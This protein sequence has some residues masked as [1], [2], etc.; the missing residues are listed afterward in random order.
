[1]R[2]SACGVLLVAVVACGIDR[3]RAEPPVKGVA[4]F[5][6]VIAKAKA[7]VFPAVAFVKPIVED[8]KAGRKMS[9]EIAGSGVVISAHGELVTNWHVVRKAVDIRVQLSDGTCVK[10]TLVGGDKETDIALVRL[11]KRP[12]KA[13]YAHAAFADSSRLE[14]GDFVMAM[15]A[16]WGLSRSVSLGILSCTRR[17]LPNQ[18]EYS[19]WL[20]TDASLNPGNSGGPLV[21]CEGKVAGVNTLAAM[22]GGDIGFAV[23]ANTVKYIVDQLRLHGEVKRSWTGVRL[24]P[25]N[26]FER[27]TFFDATEGVIVAGT[28]PQSPGR[29]AGLQAGDRITAVGGAPVTAR[30][31]EDLPAIRARL[32]S[33]EE[34]KAAALSVVREGKTLALSLTPRPKGAVEGEELDCPRWNMT[35]KTINQFDNP[36]L[37]FHRKKGVFILAVKYPG[38]AATSGLSAQDII[39]KIGETAVTALADVKAAYDKA[40]SAKRDERKVVVEVI[41]DGLTNHVVLDYAREYEDDE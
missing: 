32:G 37:Y 20:Q 11:A 4:D 22:S 2:I 3:G 12:D 25:L 33:L 6:A 38:N 10:G 35:V 15:G 34:G 9:H 8:F 18:S 13:P 21:T 29:R 28:D 14:E 40:L 39:V 23:P 16:P 26:D 19:L 24:Q 31:V 41:R 36:S 30:N 17:I 27:N 1:M 7:R 5:R